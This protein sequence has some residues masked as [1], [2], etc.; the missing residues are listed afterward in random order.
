MTRLVVVYPINPYPKVIR[1][2]IRQE[3]L[4][5]GPPFITTYVAGIP[6]LIRGGESG[7]LVPAGDVEALSDALRECLAAPTAA[8]DRMGM[9]GRQRVL[10]RHDVDTE[11]HKLGELFSRSTG[12]SLRDACKPEMSAA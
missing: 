3:V 12:G 1:S 5:L 10:S 7:W 8:L 11:A 2:F 9:S 6:N 4:T